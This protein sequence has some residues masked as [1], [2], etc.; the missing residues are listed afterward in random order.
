MNKIIVTIK[1]YL[2]SIIAIL[3]MVLIFAL[4]FPEILHSI[5]CENCTTEQ[6]PIIGSAQADLQV[7]IITTLIGGWLFTISYWIIWKEDLQ[8][9][10]EWTKNY[11]E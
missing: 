2:P 3:I 7:T 5:E 4:M 9:E 11:G 8:D 1:Y 10:K 6:A